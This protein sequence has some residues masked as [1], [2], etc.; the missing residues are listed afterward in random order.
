MSFKGYF[1]GFDHFG[2]AA[3]YYGY[4][5]L[6]L[7]PLWSLTAL[8][9]AAKAIAQVAWPHTHEYSAPR[10]SMDYD[11]RGGA[12][13]IYTRECIWCSATRTVKFERIYDTF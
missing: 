5:P 13:E 7:S 8:K 6:P 12:I 11:S 9:S 10:L 2:D 3:G 1:N 4:N